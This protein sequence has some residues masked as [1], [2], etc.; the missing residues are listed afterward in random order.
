MNGYF[1]IIDCRGILLIEVAVEKFDFFMISEN[2][3]TLRR[4][5][6][7]RH[8]PSIIFDLAGV[9]L[10]D[11]SVFGFLLETRNAIKKQGNEIAIICRDP[12]VLRV[13]EMLKVPR[14][15]RVFESR[16]TAF[17]YLNSLRDV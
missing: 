11:S 16:D 5:L 3:D 6:D 8:Y 9:R 12:E 17:D 14:I 7:D 2:S 1:N 10:I 13:M 4:L 15:I